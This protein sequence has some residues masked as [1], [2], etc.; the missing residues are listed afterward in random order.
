MFAILMMLTTSCS[1]T[2]KP[3]GT[4]TS[5]NTRFSIP[6]SLEM[7][8]SIYWYLNGDQLYITGSGPAY[9]G[10][11]GKFPWKYVSCIRDNIKHVT[12]AGE[13]TLLSPYC[14]SGLLKIESC[15]INSPVSI[16][17]MGCFQDSRQLVH[18]DLSQCEITTIPIDTFLGCGALTTVYLPSTLTRIGSYAFFGCNNLTTIFFAGSQDEWNALIVEDGNEQL[19]NVNVIFG[20]ET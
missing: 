17:G 14:F 5:H 20:K 4:E 19:L 7:N 15:A 9:G 1:H 6:H 10:S 16:I 3:P 8:D 13:I 11:G 12:V 18:V 2:D